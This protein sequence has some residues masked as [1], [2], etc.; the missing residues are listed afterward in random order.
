MSLRVSKPRPDTA[1]VSRAWLRRACL[2]GRMPAE[3]L[4]TEDREH[5]VHTLWKRGWTDVEIASR[6]VMSTYTTARIRSRLKLAALR[7]VEG[8]A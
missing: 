1:G 2:Q 8:A 3:L 4:T 5:L 7:P 6:T